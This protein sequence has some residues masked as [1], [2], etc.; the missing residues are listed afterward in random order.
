MIRLGISDHTPDFGG[1][2]NYIEIQ[3]IFFPSFDRSYYRQVCSNTHIGQ[4][5]DGKACENVNHVME[6]VISKVIPFSYLDKVS[7][8]SCPFGKHICV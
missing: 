3:V 8:V 4:S 5:Y 7:S 2:V 1:P 6:V